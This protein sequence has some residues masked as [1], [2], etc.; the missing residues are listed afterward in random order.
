MLWRQ[1]K[2]GNVDLKK[3]L[4]EGFSLLIKKDFDKAKD[5]FDDILDDYPECSQAYLGLLMTELK[6]SYFDEL[7]KSM[8]PIDSLNS[9][10]RALSFSDDT[11]K[12]KLNNILE[13]N[14]DYIQC[15]KFGKLKEQKQ[16]DNT[17][18][19]AKDY[20][21]H[22]TEKELTNKPFQNTE[23]GVKSKS[24]SKETKKMS[25][26]TS[27]ILE[28]VKFEPGEKKAI[29]KFVESKKAKIKTHKTVSA[30]SSSMA[31]IAG[32]I[33]LSIVVG[34]VLYNF[35]IGNGEKAKKEDLLVV[36][37]VN[38]N[39][40]IE[41][42]NVDFTKPME[43]K[44]Y[45]VSF[46][47]MPCLKGSFVI[48]S[49]DNELGHEN[50]EKQQQI[51][52]NKSFFIGKYEVTQQLYFAMMKVNPSRYRSF[53][54]PVENVS[55]VKAK[56]FCSN[57][58]KLTEE[59]RPEG[60]IFDLP[61]EAEWEFACRGGEKSALHNGK[62]LINEDECENLDKI[63]WYCMNSMG[64]THPVGE[65]EP[66]SLGIYDMLGNVSE[67][68]EDYYSETYGEINK[69]RQT[70]GIRVNRGGNWVKLPV[71]CR[72]AKRDFAKEDYESSRQG[73]R[74]V[75]VSR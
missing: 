63:A 73:F 30:N 18:N 14:R 42:T 62:E 71:G 24:D 60:Y 46:T 20:K 51:T 28:K 13:R 55:W 22:L 66:N 41:N 44:V 45:D 26:K 64:S 50:N 9:F 27:S 75:L 47:M 67:W 59:F 34:A 25:G 36:T 40:Q 54:K 2:M 69:E 61:T 35:V 37:E 31:I 72:C 3:Q 17:E 10:K 4:K 39:E 23:I 52:I 68:C 33:L 65:K 49:P 8:V 15:A 6:V 1:F 58:N 43:F 16:I 21:A 74:V 29:K 7:E 12:I 5:F 57:L 38:N 48:G 19:F 70:D 53:D 56:E 32:V 11:F